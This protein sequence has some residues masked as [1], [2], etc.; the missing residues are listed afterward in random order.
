MFEDFTNAL[1]NFISNKT[2]TLLSLLGIIIGVASVIMVTTIGLGATED[3]KRAFG[4]SG[5]DIVEVMPGWSLRRTSEIEFNENFRNELQSSIK[6]IKNIFYINETGGHLRRGDLDLG[7]SIKAVEPGYF[8]MMSIK[9]DYGRFFTNS[10][11]VQGIQKIILGTDAARYLFPEGKAVGKTLTLQL[12]EYQLG[13]EV[14]GVLEL[15]ESIGFESPDQNAFI[16][17]AVYSGKI[18]PNPRASRVLIQAYNQNI[19]PR[20]QRDIEQWAAEKTGNPQALYIFSMQ[21]ILDQYNQITGSLNLL[22]TGIAG[23]SLLVGGI[24]IM[25]IMIVTVTERKKEIGIRKALGASPGAI[26]MQFLV[27]SST[28][29]L[30]GGIAGIL[31][32]L[33]LSFIVVKTLNWPFIIRWINCFA[34]FIFSAVVG[35]FFGLHPAM[36]AARLDPVEAL[37]GE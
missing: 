7:L 24:G 31:L 9:L 13:F 19:T 11:Q 18:T 34:A 33:F 6:G 25:N 2:R 8:D 22:L 12:D 27:E 5:L 4:S 10:E 26:R 37:G 23:I 29:T 1:R 30:L 3:V 35:I 20:I 16:P 14:I 28:I 21:S 17:R 32:G 15:S 36:R